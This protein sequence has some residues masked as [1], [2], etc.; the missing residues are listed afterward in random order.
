M[1]S[2]AI[3]GATVRGLGDLQPCLTNLPARLS[4]YA[5]CSRHAPAGASAA[6]RLAAV[7]MPFEGDRGPATKL[8]P[9]PTSTA[10]AWLLPVPRIRLL[11]IGLLRAARCR[12]AQVAR[13]L[14]LSEVLPASRARQAHHR[15]RELRARVH[16]GERKTLWHRGSCG[17]APSLGLVRHAPRHSTVPSQARL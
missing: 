14:E 2:A 16:G 17:N 10:G 13:G 8:P 1:S 12:S 3:E 7:G 4:A 5:C 11:T 15:L 9:A 6:A